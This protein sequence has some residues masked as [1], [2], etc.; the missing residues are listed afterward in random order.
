M[1]FQNHIM[2]KIENCILNS[3]PW[4]HVIFDEFFC[5]SHYQSIIKNLPPVESLTDIR[6][7]VNVG[8][9]YCNRFVL[10]D[11]N[12][13]ENPEIREFWKK[14]YDMFLDG[15]IKNSVLR[16]FK[17]EIYNRI[18]PEIIDKI[19]FSDTVQLT[20]DKKGYKLKPHPDVF[21]K[22]FSI[23]INLNV[24]NTISMGTVVYNDKHEPVF[25]SKFNKNSAFGIF[26]SDDSWHGVEETLE[27]RWTIQYI[28]WGK[29]K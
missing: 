4:N 26:R 16:R 6:N 5:D 27:D 19:H 24:D 11:F 13:I 18:G 7:V 22:I 23:V 3:Y 28:V 12:K 21:H 20:F 29:G 10:S 8:S 9:D 25:K 2:Y 1:Y 14:T 17:T 15:N